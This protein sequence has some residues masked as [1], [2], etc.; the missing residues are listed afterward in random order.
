[1]DA[2]SPVLQQAVDK[3]GVGVVLSVIEGLS[4]AHVASIESARHG[5]FLK[6]HYPM[7]KKSQSST[8]TSRT[9]SLCSSSLS[10]SIS[11]KQML[12]H[13]NA[14]K[15]QATTT[16]SDVC[17]VSAASEVDSFVGK[18]LN[19]TTQTPEKMCKEL[20]IDTP[21]QMEQHSPEM[22]EIPQPKDSK[23]HQCGRSSDDAGTADVQQPEEVMK[24]VHTV[25]GALMKARKEWD[26][27]RHHSAQS[28]TEDAEAMCK[29]SR[30]SRDNQLLLQ[31]F[32]AYMG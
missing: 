21:Q 19:A 32:K 24:E 9:P 28:T 8:L 10:S 3:H 12:M 16:F 4:K 11:R 2:I 6:M 31:A 13:F 1:M 15:P 5:L 20:D 23:Q 29:S 17:E 22:Y 18:E 25:K 7:D 14:L 26:K 27:R 30:M